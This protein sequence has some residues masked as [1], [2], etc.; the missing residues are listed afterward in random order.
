MFR[1][2]DDLMYIND[3]H[4]PYQML[5]I[6]RGGLGYT[7]TLY[8]MVGGGVDEDTGKFF[9][10]KPST[11]NQKSDEELQEII[12]KNTEHLEADHRYMDNNGVWRSYIFPEEEK[13]KIN[14]EINIINNIIFD[15]KIKNINDIDKEIERS[16]EKIDKKEDKIDNLK[17]DI[18]YSKL[19]NEFRTKFLKEGISYMNKWDKPT[20]VSDK[21]LGEII[22]TYDKEMDKKNDFINKIIAISGD[23]DQIPDLENINIPTLEKILRLSQ[24]TKKTKDFEGEKYPV[25][26]LI[27][28]YKENPSEL[29]SL[30][31]ENFG[32]K[33]AKKLIKLEK[34]GLSI[35]PSVKQSEET[36]KYIEEIKE[37]KKGLK[38]IP[39]NIK[40]IYSVKNKFNKEYFDNPNNIKLPNIKEDEFEFKTVGITPSDFIKIN[41]KESR[42]QGK[43]IIHNIKDKF[44]DLN[45][46]KFDVLRSIIKTLDNDTYEKIINDKNAKIKVYNTGQ[47]YYDE[48][49]NLTQ[50]ADVNSPLDNVIIISSNGKVYKYAI[51]NKNYNNPSGMS[52]KSLQENP[53]NYLF[54]KKIDYNDDLFLDYIQV[55]EYEKIDEMRDLEIQIEDLKLEGYESDDEEIKKIKNSMPILPEIQDIKYSFLQKVLPKTIDIKYTK[56][57]LKPHKIKYENKGI[58]KKETYDYISQRATAHKFIEFDDDGIITKV[59]NKNDDKLDKETKLFKGSKLLHAINYPDYFVGTNYSELIKT[60]KVDKNNILNTNPLTRDY[61]NPK[62]GDLSIGY[63]PNDYDII[64][65]ENKKGK[66]NK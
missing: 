28:K 26:D 50:T 2:I 17:E 27:E 25:V 53:E 36:Q 21:T 3:G 23:E 60:G 62:L 63:F 64:K 45:D 31:D 47:D 49:G 55:E 29:N 7:P 58:S 52:K 61:Y 12:A 1:T 4:Q 24:M 19:R 56:G 59:V 44:D 16:C 57:G 30:Y 22:D 54:E 35:P 15:R 5:F 32:S 46:D 11:L 65:K 41:G 33:Q 40:N 42:I 51:E 34:K 37:Q 9:S 43:K 13:E 66:K 14:E 20:S 8:N 38:D 6:G 18:E 48:N 10:Y 39:E